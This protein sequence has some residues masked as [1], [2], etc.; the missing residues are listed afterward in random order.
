MHFDAQKLR[1]ASGVNL[2]PTTEAQ[3]FKY[4]NDRKQKKEVV[5][6]GQEK[7]SCSVSNEM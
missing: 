6:D 2:V 7:E 3:T 1:L 4:R 5:H